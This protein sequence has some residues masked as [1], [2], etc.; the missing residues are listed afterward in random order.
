ML[1]NIYANVW[2]ALELRSF[3]KNL[4][5]THKNPAKNGGRDLFLVFCCYIGSSCS[6]RFPRVREQKLVSRKW[7]TH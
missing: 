4:D 6:Y 3:I 2:K 7:S 1:R 5:N